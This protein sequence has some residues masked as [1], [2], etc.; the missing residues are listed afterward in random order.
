MKVEFDYTGNDIVNADMTFV[1]VLHQYDTYFNCSKGRLKMREEKD[2][3]SGFMSC[4]LIHYVRENTLCP[5]E[6]NVLISLVKLESVEEYKELLG[7]ALG[8]L[9]VVEKVR[10]LYTMRGR[11]RVHF[12]NVIGL[13]KFLEIEVV[14]DPDESVEHG[15]VEAQCIMEQFGIQNENI[16]A[17]SY[18]D[19]LIAARK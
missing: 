13:G 18:S 1:S 5:K 10:S 19:L 4:R 6:S 8:V 11:T 17:E 2:E 16:I 3:I 14:L 15:K 9:V 12:D 7:R